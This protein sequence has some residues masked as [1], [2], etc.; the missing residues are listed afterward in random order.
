[1]KRLILIA[2]AAAVAFGSSGRG[3][4]EQPSKLRDFMRRKLVHSQKALEGI[5]VKD[6][7]L[8]AQSAQEMSLLSLDASWQ[9]L[10]TPEY[11]QRSTEF[12]RTANTLDRRARDKNLDGAALSYIQLTTQ[13]F[14]CHKYVRDRR[15]EEDQPVN[16]S[17]DLQ[18]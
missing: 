11:F 15:Q 18:P 14:D 1:M 2:V 7:D 13:C 3:Q 10:Q 6:F 4:D 5:V 17:A 9:V 8:I 12:R 16:R